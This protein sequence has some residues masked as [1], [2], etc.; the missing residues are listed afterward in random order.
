VGNES[1]IRNG[2]GKLSSLS[3][4]KGRNVALVNKGVRGGRGKKKVVRTFGQTYSGAKGE[5]SRERGKKAP[6]SVAPTKNRHWKA[7]K[8]ER[9]ET[10]NPLRKEGVGRTEVESH[11]T[12]RR[13]PMGGAE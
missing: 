2:R 5:K 7:N 6:T 9:R 4:K 10:T 11:R 13:R 12:K 3:G 8:F 1:E